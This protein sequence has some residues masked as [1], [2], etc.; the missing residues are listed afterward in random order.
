MRKVI[1]LGMLL[2]LI[3]VIV[4][5]TLSAQDSAWRVTGTRN[6]EVRAG[7]GA[8]IAL[9]SPDGAA[10]AHLGGADLCM[11][12][13][14]TFDEL[15]CRD[16]GDDMR[17]V[18]R[19]S[20]RWSP[21]SRYVT[22]TEDFFRM[23]FKPSIW[24]VEADTGSVRSLT[25]L[26]DDRLNIGG[27]TWPDLDLLPT[28]DMDADTPVLYFLRLTKRDG[29]ESPPALYRFDDL[30]AEPVEVGPLHDFGMLATY[31]M[32]IRGDTIIYN[33]YIP[34]ADMRNGAWVQ[35]LTGAEPAA[36]I[37]EPPQPNL[38][39]F[40]VNL[41]PDGRY[42]LATDAR[43]A[44]MITGAPED[45]PVSLIDLASGEVLVIDPA[46]HVFAAGWNPDGTAL[47]YLA[48]N[49]RDHEANGLYIT[50]EAGTPGTRVLDGD[51]IP[52]TSL[53]GQQPLVWSSQNTLLI[54]EARSAD[55]LLVTLAPE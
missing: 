23:L 12:D 38:P 37:V 26:S 31:G 34:N 14:D 19:T 24:L 11:Y 50:T 53:M 39:I 43:L 45:T 46:N 47:A 49:G 17:G 16:L 22:V 5:G 18:D 44:M 13:T 21:D 30:D 8:Q 27:D 54:A 9:L 28:F 29:V 48:F 10:I 41:S 40:A 42:A 35:S 33:V 55:A 25:S 7:A 52:S 6:T 20:L 1:T 4:V 36:Q 32:D 3:S 2:I 15:W 51:F